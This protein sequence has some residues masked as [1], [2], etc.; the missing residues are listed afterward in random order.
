[1]LLQR[2]GKTFAAFDAGANVPDRVAHDLVGRLVGQRLQGLDDGDARV[3]HGGQL[4]R[5]HHQICQRHLAALGL[6]LLGDLLLD[7]HHQQI[8]VE[9]RGDGGLFGGGLHGVA[10]FA[11]GG[12]FSGGIGK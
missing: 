8:A 2:L 9:Q 12:R 4:A 6:A 7:V 1:M 3:N 5:E 11:A 10:D